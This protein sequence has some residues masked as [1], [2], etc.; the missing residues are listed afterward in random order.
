MSE[1]IEYVALEECAVSFTSK[2]DPSAIFAHLTAQH[3]L[4]EDD[5]QV[6]MNTSRTPREN[7][8]YIM[9]IL[10]RKGDGWFD[11]LLRC[12]HESADGTGHGDLL[13]ELE[14]KRQELRER[15]NTGTPET[16][17]KHHRIS[18]RREPEE[19]QR[20]VVARPE[21]VRLCFPTCLWK[22]LGNYYTN[23]LAT[24]THAHTC[25][26]TSACLHCMHARTHALAHAHTH[27]CM[28]THRSLCS[29]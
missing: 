4:T 13:K 19:E 21:E 9:H 15:R 6:L 18:T 22:L 12:L 29:V 20:P 1:D 8:K 24:H 10:P 14:E 5:K 7:S 11:K 23:T 2:L 17:K 16:N 26:H 28:H 27:A 3:L 25:I